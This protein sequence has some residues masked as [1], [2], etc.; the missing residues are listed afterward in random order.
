MKTIMNQKLWL[1]EK[2]A[3]P[4][5]AENGEGPFWN[6]LVS[7]MQH[8]IDVDSSSVSAFVVILVDKYSNCQLNQ[9]NYKYWDG[10]A[11]YIDAN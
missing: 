7:T 4:F 11:V 5:G 10:N 6:Y 3:F 2:T 1:V 8:I 9:Y